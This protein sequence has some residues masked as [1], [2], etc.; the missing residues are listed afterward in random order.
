MENVTS[1]RYVSTRHLIYETGYDGVLRA[2][3]FDWEKL[4]IEGE[5]VP[6]LRGIR[7]WDSRAAL[8]WTVYPNGT[9]IFI[10]GDR[11]GIHSLVWV[12]REGKE[13]LLPIEPGLLFRPRLSPEG[14]HF[15]VTRTDQGTAK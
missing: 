8:D 15:A 4:S 5:G 13:E 2:V 14:N 12:D 3:G 10:P 1:L 6:V 11:K 9:L 7:A